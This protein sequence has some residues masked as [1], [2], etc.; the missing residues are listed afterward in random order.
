MKADARELFREGR[1]KEAV[2]AQAAEVK[3][4]PVDTARR[5]FLCELLCFSGELERVDTHLDSMGKQDPQAMPGIALFRQ[6]VR[7]EQARR[8]FFSQGRVP[9]FLGEPTPSA[10]LA[11]EASVHL[12]EGDAAAAADLLRRAEEERPRATGSSGEKPFED[13][14]DLDDVTAGVFEVL[15]SNGKYYWVPVESV[16]YLEFRPAVRPRDILWRRARMVVRD[17]PDGEVFLPSIYPP[18]KEPLEDAARLGRVTEWTGGEG[19]PVRGVGLRTFLVG[20]GAVPI[21]DLGTL[22]FG[23]SGQG[24]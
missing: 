8:E 22:E 18:G 17:G 23:E 16:S 15:T 11:L 6:L 14:R 5:G 2:A 19:E 24:A 13:F 12:R 3:S 7:A 4:H 20:E 9:E 10:R 21:L 1:L